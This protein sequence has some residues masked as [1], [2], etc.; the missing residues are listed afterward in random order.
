MLDA[1]L[2]PFLN[3]TLYKPARILAE[4]GV[5][6][7]QVTWAG[8]GFSLLA[9][10]SVALGFY[11]AG[12][13]FVLAGRVCDGLDGAVARLT[14]ITDFGGYLDIVLDMIFYSGI[15]FAFAVSQPQHAL[16]AAF[17]IFSFVTTGSS[18]LAYAIIAAKR[19]ITTETRGQKS[20]YYMGGLCEGAETITAL[21]LM[22]LFPDAFPW[23]AAVFGVLCLV[24]AAGRILEARAV[25]SAQF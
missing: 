8:F 5:T 7:D 25:F 19:N 18:F 23:T 10:A 21:L 2:R 12:V 15:I 1:Y 11:G 17:L 24:T 22:C 3:K 9:M 20:F 16:Y 13:F 4:R 6:A 14:K